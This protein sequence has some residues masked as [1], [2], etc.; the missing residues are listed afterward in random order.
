MRAR[1]RAVIIL[2]LLAT[3]AGVRAQQTPPPLIATCTVPADRRWSD[4]EKMVW[5]RACVGEVADFN[6][7]PHYGGNVDARIALLPERRIL[8]SKFIE[9]ILTEDPYRSAMKRYG[10]RVTG[11]RFRERL[12]LQN[13][14]VATE[15]WF[16]QC[17]FE[18]GADLS[19]FR[20]TQP[21]AFNTSRASGSLNLYA[22]Q[23]TS[24]VHMTD[25]VIAEVGL[26][27]A[28]I[29]RTLDLSKSRIASAVDMG[30]STVG[31]DLAMNDGI[32]GDVSLLGAHVGH[33][34]SLINSKVGGGL[35][36]DGLQVG[37]DLSMQNAELFDEVGLRY[38]QIG[39]QLD[40]SG[41]VFHDDVDLSGAHVGGE[42]VLDS[43]KWWQ[44]VSLTARYTKIGVI[45]GFSDAWPDTLHVFGLTYD[46]IAETGDDFQPWFKRQDVYTRQPYEHLA[47]VL[48]ARGDI[49]RATAV[50]VAE[51]D[52]DRS[53]QAWY[54]FGWLTLLKYLIGYGYYP[55]YSLVWIAGFVILGALVLRWSGEGRRNQMPIGLSYSFDMLLPVI[56]L[57]ES[58]YQIDLRGW[59][60]YY[61]YVHRLMGWALASFLVAGLSGLT[62]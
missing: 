58:H 18:Q 40:W 20:S 61:F 11:A 43:A 6:T 31:V 59:P 45:P 47:G 29:G 60:R 8:R 28:Q 57:R 24:D 16:E 7:E 25:S 12:D 54:I 3:P 23:I 26:V 22:A 49:E 27:A 51:R 19:W 10:V 41:G 35:Q 48:Q 5:A 56:R 30:G 21:V 52:R 1:F 38:A 33:A 55:Y 36:M 14:E 62:K 9:T 46:G 34:A 32:Y 2:A 53:G 42:L 17:L 15:L 4:Q 13:V 50:R 44:G 37:T 39:G